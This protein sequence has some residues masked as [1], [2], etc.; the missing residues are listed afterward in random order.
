VKEASEKADLK[1]G[2][3]AEVL[4][5]TQTTYSKYEAARA[6][7]MPHHLIAPF[8]IATRVK[9]SGCMIG[10]SKLW[11]HNSIRILGI[12]GHQT[13]SREPFL[14]SSSVISGPKSASIFLGKVNSLIRGKR[15]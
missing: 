12:S 2:E 8:C 14:I 7:L 4:R 15:H 5:V 13:K 9:V 3:I 6:S 10:S 1:K 11:E